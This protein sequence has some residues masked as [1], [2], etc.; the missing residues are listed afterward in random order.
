MSDTLNSE[1]DVGIIQID[2]N[3]M[4]ALP[5]TRDAG[6]SR[7]HERVEHKIA[8]IRGRRDTTLQQSY[9]LL[10]WVLPKGLFVFPRCR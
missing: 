10:C 8:W 4:S 2:P 5:V 7:P 1:F 6:C 9:R 3:E